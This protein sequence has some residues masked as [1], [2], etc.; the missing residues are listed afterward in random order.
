MVGPHDRADRELTAQTRG[1][2]SPALSTAILSVVRAFE[3]ADKK[4]R[5][6]QQ[7]LLPV[8]GP[9]PTP[10]TR[11]DAWISTASAR[12]SAAGERDL[13]R[14]VVDLLPVPSAAATARMALILPGG[15]AFVVLQ[16]DAVRLGRERPPTTL[17]FRAGGR[18]ASAGS[19]VVVTRHRIV[20]RWSTH[21]CILRPKMF[22]GRLADGP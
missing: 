20:R 5:V 10:S 22:S 14:A 15:A 7:L 11:R 21:G 3:P 19:L 13:P 2:E 1:F 9:L 17:S 6:K 16:A 12:G 18:V 4:R 8:P